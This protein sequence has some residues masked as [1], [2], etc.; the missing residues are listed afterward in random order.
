MNI[1]LLNSDNVSSTSN[2]MYIIKRLYFHYGMFETIFLLF[3]AILSL[4]I[5]IAHANTY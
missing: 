3:T 5:L 2:L 4:I 1:H